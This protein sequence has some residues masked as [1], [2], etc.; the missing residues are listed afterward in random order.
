VRLLGLVREIFHVSVDLGAFFKNPT[1]TALANSIRM[2]A[3]DRAQRSAE[4]FRTIEQLPETQVEEML[5]VLEQG[6]PLPQ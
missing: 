4:L 1:I 6:Q 2:L 5:A 3:G